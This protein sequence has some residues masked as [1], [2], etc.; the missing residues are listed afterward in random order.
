MCSRS[1]AFVAFP[2]GKPVS[3][4]LLKIHRHRLTQALLYVPPRRDARVCATLLQFQ[5]ASPCVRAALRGQFAHILRH[6][7]NIFSHPAWHASIAVSPISGTANTSQCAGVPF[8]H[9]DAVSREPRSGF[10]VVSLELFLGLAMT[11]GE[12]Y[13]QYAAECVRVAQQIQNPHDKA[14]LLDMALRWRELAEKVESD[15]GR[16]T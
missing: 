1:V 9:F 4:C 11:P 3:R 15:S 13:R 12:E 14:L 7:S 5:A 16:K 2:G 10:R 6:T 8:P